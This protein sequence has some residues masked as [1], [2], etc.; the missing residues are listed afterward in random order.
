LFL[1]DDPTGTGAVDNGNVAVDSSSVLGRL[2]SVHNTTSKSY[3][4]SFVTF[5]AGRLPK[6]IECSADEYSIETMGTKSK[7]LH[8]KIVSQSYMVHYDLL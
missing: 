1:G 8:V 3:L 5:S 6:K 7:G 2:R 4:P